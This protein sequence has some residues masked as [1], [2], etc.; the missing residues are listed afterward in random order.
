MLALNWSC[1]LLRLQ[2]HLHSAE[3]QAQNFLHGGLIAPLSTKLQVAYLVMSSSL[4]HPNISLEKKHKNIFVQ[5]KY[6]AWNLGSFPSMHLKDIL[7]NNF[8]LVK[9]GDRLREQGNSW[10]WKGHSG[11][12]RKDEV[13]GQPGVK[14]KFQSS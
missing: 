13:W 11:T 4:V 7:P 12:V 2:L 8:L 14:S 3:Y 10:T 9:G 5:A 1:H 6:F